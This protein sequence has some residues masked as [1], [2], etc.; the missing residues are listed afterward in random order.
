MSTRFP[1]TDPENGTP[2]PGAVLPVSRLVG[3]ARRLLERHIGLVWVSGEISDYVRAASGHCYFSLKER[4]SVVRCVFY[5]QKAQFASFP[6]RNGLQVEVRATATIYE[7]RGDFQLNVE[8]VRLAGIGALYEKY[9]RLK[10]KLEAAG[11][12]DPEAKRALP[13]L[14]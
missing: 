3:S 2:L 1:P 7:P 8:V 14:P 6:L 11:W 10:A 4:E 9:A 13:P 12:F 5:R